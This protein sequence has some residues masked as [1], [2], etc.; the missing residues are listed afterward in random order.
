MNQYNTVCGEIIFGAGQQLLDAIVDHMN[1]CTNK[2]CKTAC[3]RAAA[4]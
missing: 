4:R 2:A 1:R 3:W